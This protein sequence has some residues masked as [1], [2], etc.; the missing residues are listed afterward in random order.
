M[1]SEIQAEPNKRSGV[2]ATRYI[3]NPTKATPLRGRTISALNIL[4][5]SLCET[6]TGCQPRLNGTNVWVLFG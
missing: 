4:T 1:P 6:K 2:C 3:P 5:C